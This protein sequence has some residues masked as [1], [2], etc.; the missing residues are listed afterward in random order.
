[1]SATTRKLTSGLFS[2]I[3]GLAAALIVAALAVIIGDA[4][5]GGWSK[6]SWE[7][8]TGEPTEGMTAGGIFPAIWGTTVL[9]LMMTVAVMPVGVMTAI[10]LHEYAPVQSRLAAAVRV[11][12][13]NLAG[14]PSIV[15]GLFG[16][17]FF[18]HFLGEGMDR[19]LG[20]ELRYG[21]PGL[22]WA[23]LTL[24]V[25]TLP[26]VIVATEE[27]LRAVPTD[28]RNASL[29]LGATKSQTLWRIVLPGA[30]P[31]ILT[32]AILA[33]S[34]GAGEVAPILLTGAAYFLPELPSTINSQFMHLG[35]HTYV[36]ATQ[37]PDVEATR[38][39]LYG[40]VLVL[41]ML[42]FTLNFVAVLLRSRTRSRANA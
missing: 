30:T 18:I 29:A 40:T 42:T 26:V 24:A 11:A 13:Q 36:L 8:F 19:A 34:R 27:A 2:G 39:L 3:S 38:P 23:S 6:L 16:L 7:F 9:T 21:Q 12:V 35:Y 15:F 20:G 22:L 5:A 31:G 1:M 32:G 41:L 4:V 28:L 33:V 37:S 17:G 14:V 25:L 10:Y